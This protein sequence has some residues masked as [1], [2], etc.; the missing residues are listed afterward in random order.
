M[1]VKRES[2][3]RNRRAP[4]TIACD[5]S[6]PVRARWESCEPRPASRSSFEA[7]RRRA[8]A[9]CRCRRGPSKW[10][11]RRSHPHRAPAVSRPH[12]RG[13]RDERRIYFGV[14][15]NESRLNH[16]YQAYLDALFKWLNRRSQKRSFN[17]ERFRRR[18]LHQPLPKPPHGHA[19]IDV[20][21]EHRT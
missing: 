10:S 20:T 8:G 21:S 17:W 18:L 16:F 11:R 15:F 5:R 13:A 9:R 6:A 19:L 1:A 14:R 4:S 2:C 3:R 12:S 7:G